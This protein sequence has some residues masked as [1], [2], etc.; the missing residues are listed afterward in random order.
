MEY[1][2]VGTSRLVVRISLSSLAS[3][4]D[5]C[6]ALYYAPGESWRTSGSN[7]PRLKFQISIS[8]TSLNI[9]CS[10]TSESSSWGPTWTSQICIFMYYMEVSILAY[11]RESGSL[12][13][14]GFDHH[15]WAPG[16]PGT[17]AE[18]SRVPPGLFSTQHLNIPTTWAHVQFTAHMHRQKS[19]PLQQISSMILSKVS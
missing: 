8:S 5:I 9:Q 14:S 10:N 3:A 11:L 6:N 7:I 4:S 19:S 13:L 12:R 2:C 15:V 1:T 16:H 18:P 17:W